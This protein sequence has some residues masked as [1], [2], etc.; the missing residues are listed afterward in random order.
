MNFLYYARITA[1]YYRVPQFFNI[2]KIFLEI[3]CAAGA[4]LPEN[5]TNGTV[6]YCG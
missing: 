5:I 6:Y 4:N 2:L 1:Q 3:K